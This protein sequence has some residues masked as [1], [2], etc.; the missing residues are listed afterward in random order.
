MNKN[1]IVI[2]IFSFSGMLVDLGFLTVIGVGMLVDLGVCI[3]IVVC[4]L[5]DLGLCI[6]GMLVDLEF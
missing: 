3:P 2:T 6:V 4:I 1:R 5:V